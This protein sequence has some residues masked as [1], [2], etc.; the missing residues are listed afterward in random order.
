MLQWLFTERWN[1]WNQF[2]CKKRDDIDGISSR[3]LLTSDARKEN[4][5]DASNFMIDEMYASSAWLIR[6]A[7]SSKARARMENAGRKEQ[8]QLNGITVK[9]KVAECQETYSSELNPA[10]DKN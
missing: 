2:P 7:Q 9:L 10:E 8:L 6:L 1:Q 4:H 5:W 3:S